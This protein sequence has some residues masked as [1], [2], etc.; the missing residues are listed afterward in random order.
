L[1]KVDRAVPA[2]FC[3]GYRAGTARST[4][5]GYE[6]RPV[7]RIDAEIFDDGIAAYVV[8]FEVGFRV[9]AQAVVEKVVL[10]TDAVGFGVE[11]F[12]F[13]HDARHRFL[14]GERQDRVQVIGHEEKESDVPA[15]ALVVVSGGVQQRLAECLVGEGFGE[16]G[17]HADAD[18]EA[19]AVG[20]PRWCCVVESLAERKVDR[21]VPARFCRGY[22]D[23]PGRNFSFHDSWGSSSSSM[24][25][26]SSKSTRA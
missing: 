13:A 4:S 15:L 3:W 9:V 24:R 21:A 11:P 2:R 5:E 12:P 23:P 20:D 14:G 6:P 22:R 26:R 17:S 16:I 8:V 1:G 19:C 10:P 7:V 18:V 25:W